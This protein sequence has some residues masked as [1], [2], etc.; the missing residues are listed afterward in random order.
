ML[1]LKMGMQWE[2]IMAFRRSNFGTEWNKTL[3]FV[4]VLANAVDCPA[5][6]EK[7]RD[8]KLLTVLQMYLLLIAFK[9]ITLLHLK[10]LEL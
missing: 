2:K 8:L 5:H 1:L 10:I 7:I 4:T 3:S 9:S 6:P